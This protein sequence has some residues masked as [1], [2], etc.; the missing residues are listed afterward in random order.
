MTPADLEHIVAREL[1]ALPA[2]DAPHTLLPRVLAAVQAWSRRPWYSRAWFTWPVAG[3]I[4]SVTALSLLAVGGAMLLPAAHATAGHATSTVSA[5]L[6]SEMSLVVER[7]VLTTNVAQV[8]WRALVEP[9]MP[10]AFALVVLMCV[11]CAA[12]GTVL[13]HAVFGRTFQS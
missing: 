2:L 1:R 8:V 13:N 3:Q 7:V 10:Y 9:V 5:G 4:V 12:F 11:A 6:N